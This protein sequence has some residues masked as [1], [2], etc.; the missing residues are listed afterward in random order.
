M[1]LEMER[2]HFL[3][4]SS[5]YNV[6]SVLEINDAVKPVAQ[7]GREARPPEIGFTRKFLA[8]PLS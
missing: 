7:P 4:H 8:A 2:V 3:T 5:L 1:N 6:L